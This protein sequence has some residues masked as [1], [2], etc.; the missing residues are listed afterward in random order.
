MGYSSLYQMSYAYSTER[1]DAG[2]S[3]GIVGVT[4]DGDHLLSGGSHACLPLENTIK[5]SERD[6]TDVSKYKNL[7]VKRKYRT[8]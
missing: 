6:H 3:S 1:Q 8:D 4:G 2:V 7:N 5:K